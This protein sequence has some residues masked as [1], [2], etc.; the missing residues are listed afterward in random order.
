[1][2]NKVML[3]HAETYKNLV[4]NLQ[5]C[6]IVETYYENCLPPDID[7]EELKLHSR[8]FVANSR[9]GNIYQIRYAIL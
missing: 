4:F 9:Y 3:K 1:M 5:R 7:L 8:K 6:L 2:Q